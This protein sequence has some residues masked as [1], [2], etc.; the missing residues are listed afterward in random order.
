VAEPR[1]GAASLGDPAPQVVAAPVR[2]PSVPLPRHDADVEAH[3]RVRIGQAELS[4]APMAV[5]VRRVLDLARQHRPHA[6][7]T[8]NADH[9]VRLEKDMGLLAAY[10][11][12]SLAVIDG[13][14]LV[15]AGRW[16][17]VRAERITGVDLFEQVCAEADES[18]R[19]FLLGGSEANSARAEQVLRRR[20]PQLQI[21]GRNT[22]RVDNEATTG[23]IEQ[24]RA[25]DA[26]VVAV[27]YGCP[28]QEIWVHTNRSRLPGGVYLCI[29]GTVDIISGAL[30]RAGR[31]WQVL[32][33]EWLHRL[34]LEPRRLWRRYLVEDPRFALI[35]LRSIARSRRG[36]RR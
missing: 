36:R 5:T 9:I 29:G 6:V 28:K 21:V 20:F 23:I 1:R 35:A 7:V 3:P 32:G 27:F 22:D 19:L 2:R 4:C 12:A 34:L 10:R 24:I 30:P 18:I 16:M 26:N 25:S 33:L 15:W 13:K 14:P 8:A 17:S 11:G 31:V